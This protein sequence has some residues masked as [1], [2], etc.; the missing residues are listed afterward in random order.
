MNN[1]TSE[2]V[3]RCFGRYLIDLPAD[4]KPGRLSGATF[5]IFPYTEYSGGIRVK[6]ISMSKEQFDIQLAKREDELKAKHI[7]AEPQQPY[8]DN[9]ISLDDRTGI[10]FNRSENGGSRGARTLELHGWK[11]GYAIKMTIDAADVSYPEYQEDKQLQDL[12]SNVQPKLAMLQSLYARTSGRTNDEIPS[13]PGTCI[14]NGFISGPASDK[15]SESISMNFVSRSMPDV[16]FHLATDNV[17]TKTTLLDR[18]PDIR[19][20]LDVVHG[21]VIRDRSSVTKS[22][23]SYEE[24]LTTKQMDDNNPLMGQSFKLE[25]NSKM[26]KAHNPLINVSFDNGKREAPPGHDESDLLSG[27]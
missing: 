17:H 1:Y 7:D 6:V 23:Q 2:M 18:M 15:M 24:V 27:G 13:G 22:G 4:M 21:H 5:A 3:P 25:A 16:I 11:D 8:L 9:T 10:I 12:G 20:A 14:Q 19:H 26:G